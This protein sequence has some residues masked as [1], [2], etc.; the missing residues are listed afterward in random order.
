MSLTKVSYSMI[1]H[2]PVNVMDFGAV[3]NGVA[4]DTAALQEALDAVFANVGGTLRI[5]A[6]N[7]KI[8]ADLVP[9]INPGGSG[10]P[11]L[12]RFFRIIGDGI[13]ST[14]ILGGANGYGLKIYG[15]TPPVRN[16]AFVG[17]WLEG[18]SMVGSGLTGIGIDIYSMQR[19]QLSNVSASGYNYGLK[20][21][22]SWVNSITDRCRFENNN[23]GI[24]IPKFNDTTADANEGVNSVDFKGISCSL[25]TKAG[26]S[27]DYA[28]LIS[29][30]D[31]LL[32]SCPVGIYLLQQI[33]YIRMNTLYYEAG[34]VTPTRN[35]RAGTPST[36]GIY[37]GSN[38]DFEV[39]NA[40]FPIETV[41]IDMMQEYFGQGKVYLDNV[42][43]VNIENP[44][45]GNDAF[46]EMSDRASF[47]QSR[48]VATDPRFCSMLQNVGRSTARGVLKKYPHNLISNGSMI[49]PGLPRI[50]NF[51]GTATTARTNQTIGGSS[52]RVMAI[53]LP[54]GETTNAFSFNANIGA[55]F[56]AGVA[57]SAGLRAKAS[58]ADIT[59]VKISLLNGNNDVLGLTDEVTGA[60]VINWFN[61]ADTGDYLSSLASEQVQLRVEITRS[62]AASSDTLWINE[63]IIAH[64]EYAGEV[65]TGSAFDLE[66]GLAGVVTPSTSSGA[67]F[68]AEVNPEVGAFVSDAFRVIATPRYDGTQTAAEVQVQYLGGADDG[69]FRIWCNRTGV[70]IDY[71]ILLLNHYTP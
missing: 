18:F 46:A 69:K 62:T 63:A 25:N 30:E 40:T 42:V 34:S 29:I 68:F 43:N 58:S 38:E 6:G 48:S 33:Q 9:K 14:N 31:V 20:L 70:T 24:K 50:R 19:S 57:F 66:T 13:D 12:N 23:V 10:N 35:N 52:Q 56:E 49:L 11:P 53:T 45:V 37:C 21:R 28:N 17:V 32:E 26:I 54:I 44:R 47:V 1:D 55:E 67:W 61:L 60:D 16:N 39:G 65:V 3:G 8:T 71:R 7:Y 2:A 22:S 51:T 41:S 4:D 36:Y 64:R 27:I 15:A 5:P 59:K